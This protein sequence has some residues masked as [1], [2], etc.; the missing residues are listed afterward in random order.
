MFKKII[1]CASIIIFANAVTGCASIVSDSHYP[2]SINSTPSGAGFDVVNKK[3]DMVH[4]GITPEQVNL[5][6]GSGY[7]SGEKYQIT[8][9]KEDYSPK[10]TT[11]DTTVD[12]WYWAN[13]LFGGLI[14][15][16]IFDPITGAMYKLPEKSH[17]SLSPMKISEKSE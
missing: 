17:T 10:I 3:G 15:M 9:A 12:G 11:I 8:Y 13:L 2:V 6:A 1:S 7:F 4:S 14:G 16:L 5:K